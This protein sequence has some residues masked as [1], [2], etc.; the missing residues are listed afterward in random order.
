MA[1]DA[2]VLVH[3]LWTSGFEFGVMGRRP[4]RDHEPLLNRCLTGPVLLPHFATIVF[5]GRLTEE[6]RTYAPRI[7]VGA[8]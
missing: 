8:V 7:G 6:R 3:G 1:R 2:I 5:D 4:R